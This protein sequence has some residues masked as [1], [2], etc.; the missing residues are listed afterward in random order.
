MT[1]ALVLCDR[2]IGEAH[3]PRCGACES[4]ANEYQALNIPKDKPTMA[5]ADHLGD[6]GKRALDAMRADRNDAINRARRAER[7]YNDLMRGIAK[8]VVREL[9]DAKYIE[10]HDIDPNKE[11]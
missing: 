4:L 10:V 6:P 11:N 8:A 7:R 9:Q 2:H 3:A 1:A 5:D